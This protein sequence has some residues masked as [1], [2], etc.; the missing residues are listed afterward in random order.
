MLPRFM[1]YLSLSA[2]ALILIFSAAVAVAQNARFSGQI[3]DAQGGVIPKA[4]VEITNLDTGVQLQTVS[5]DTGNYSV[6]YL[7]AGRYRIIVRAS[8]FDLSAHE[9]AL[10][11]GQALI[12]NVQLT[13]AGA[14]TTVSVQAGSELTELHLETNEI[15]G[16]I[17]GKEVTGIQLNGRNFTQLMALAPGVSNQTQQDEARVGMA[18]SVS[19]SVNG[20]R[21]EYNSFQADGSELLNVGINKDHTSLIVTPSIDAIQE[22]KVLTS[23]YGAMYPSTGNG[24]TIVTTKSGT[25]SYHGSFYEFFRNEDLNAKGYFD[26]GNN[27]PLYRRNDF[28]GTIGGPLS[29]PHIYDAKGKTHFFF[30]EEARIEKDPYAYR[31]A[32]P[33]LAERNGDFSDLCPPL[34]NGEFTSFS[35]TKYPDCPASVGDFTFP[36]N[37]ISYPEQIV[38]SPFALN[39]NALAILGTGI[40]PLPNA[41][42][43]CN[44]T[45]TACYLTDVSLPTYWRQ[46]LFR[47]DHAINAKW[48]A[49]FRYIHDEW[50]ETTPVPQ[51]AYT[52]NSFPTIQNRF[53]APG[54]SLVGRLT[55]AFSS[56][57]LNEF[58]ASYTDSYIT[59]SDLAGPGA[60]LER[61]AALSAPCSTSPDGQCG[62]TTI[63]KNGG[64]GIDGV[65]KIPGIVIGGNNGAYGGYGFASDPGYMPWQHTNPTYSF[66]DNLNKF[67]G[68][69]NLQFGVQWIVFQR[70]QTNGP[71]GAATGDVQGLYNFSNVGSKPGTGN[72]FANFLFTQIDPNGNPMQNLGYI[73]SFQQ[74]S[75]QGRYRQRYQ[76]VEPYFQDDFKVTSHLTLNLGLRVSLFGTY[77]EAGNQTYNWEQ[78]AFSTTAASTVAIG[79]DD[80]LVNA[81]DQ[82]PIMINQSDPQK[83]LDPRIING[84]VHCGTG[85]IPSSCMS[86]HLFN[87]APRVGFA[88]DPTG[89]GKLALRGGYG[90]F[91][92]HGTSDEANTGSLEAGAPLVLNMTQSGT[93]QTGWSQIGGGLAYPINVTSIPT[94]AVWPYVQQWS[95][96]V[97]HQFPGNA[98]ATVAYVGSAGHHLTAELEINQLTPL[99]AS[100]NPFGAHVPLQTQIYNPVVGG[101]IYQGDCTQLVPGNSSPFTLM[102][103]AVVAPGSPAYANMQAACL[104]NGG[105]GQANGLRTFAPGLGEIYSLQD[106]ANSS[107]HA[108]QTTM[109]K[110]QGPLTL[111]IAYTYSHSLDNASDRSDATFV[112]S[113]NLAGNRASSNFDQRHLLH[114]SYIYDLPLV[115]F[116]D[117]LLHFADSDPT[118][119][120]ANSPDHPYDAKAWSSSKAVQTILAGWQLSGLTLFESGIP[121][122]VVNNGSPT[123]VSTLDNA[124]VANGVGSGSYP[125]L[126]GISAHYHLPAGG[127]N[128]KSFGPLLLNPAAFVAPRGLTFGNAGR[129]DLN[130]PHR[131]NWDVAAMKHIPIGE[132]LSADFRVEAFNINNHTQF[133]IY[134]PT[135][136]PQ[137]QNEV[138]CYG[139]DAAYYSAAGG[140]GVDCLTGSSFLHPVDAHRPRTIQA[141]LKFNF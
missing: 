24:T 120:A 25:D 60:T 134:D 116:F 85:S 12:F 27:A 8:G 2:F 132:R 62:L 118:N 88:W 130:N 30:S 112:N 103:G 70:N 55:T 11:M 82:S 98:L 29:I 54:R 14:Q 122:T 63:F 128:S 107:Y 125:D 74:D 108:F 141:A 75:G 35:R 97:E 39:Q 34:A 5:D 23:N 46:E 131:T 77:H 87:P 111:G 68:R 133:R 102:S 124:G 32:V 59:L 76:I 86:G 127:N 20:G 6:P 110:V 66:S 84:I 61:P 49:N 37:Q 19:Y 22:I 33:S 16:T 93:G 9:A 92:E 114:I 64:K 26:I 3:T 71:I 94:K 140:D 115:H 96:S 81:S 28:G 91:F 105:G 51:Y 73:S 78:S 79:N 117:T 99:S 100:G 139:G 41:T 89:S 119:E 7:S 52:E 137:A 53:Y 69:H 106:V 40:I 38:G 95:L 57:F 65:P 50:D 4:A 138:S 18:G 1:K 90:I 44:S 48:Q 31:Q 10:G 109:R 80:N 58:V 47:I 123:G 72:A 104:G 45:G 21:T 17:T 15:S 121:F 67:I 42:T 36:S 126:S 101:N 43:G 56:T 13:V 83:G 129:N 136:G 135:L 113:F